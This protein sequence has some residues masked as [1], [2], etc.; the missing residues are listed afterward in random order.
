[1]RTAR[2]VLRRFPGFVLLAINVVMSV[3]L[4][5]GL[6]VGLRSIGPK[7]LGDRMSALRFA[8]RATHEA[9]S[10][11]GWKYETD[12]GRFLRFVPHS[13]FKVDHSEYHNDAWIDE[14]GG[15]AIS[16]PLRD[17]PD[18]VPVFGDSFTFGVGVESEETAVSLLQRTLTQRLLNLGV[19]GSAI[20][21]QRYIL[22][23]RY[24]EL[25]RPK[26]AIFFF[27]L[28]NDFADVLAQKRST[29]RPT[30][31]SRDGGDSRTARPIR[32]LAW[33]VNDFVNSS[34]LRF[35]FALQYARQ[36]ILTVMNRKADAVVANPIFLI[37]SRE[38]SAYRSEVSA[39]VDQ[40]LDKLELFAL[41]VKLR[42]IVVAVPDRN[43]VCSALARSKVTSTGLDYAQLDFS[44]PNALLRELVERHHFPLIDPTSSFEH[45]PDCADLYYT[46]DDHLTAAGQRLLAEAVAP[47]IK[48]ALQGVAWSR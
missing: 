27:F 2:N 32:G 1:M 25:D 28:G 6:E 13:H 40:E 38:Q 7:W 43:Q 47:A 35:S 23:R 44:I 30:G 24:E 10:D 31:V 17:S 34:P 9:G 33:R 36:A 41:G 8:K 39:A 22:E 42:V 12:D 18:I 20:H 16:S 15:R 37:A 29:T 21:A 11:R 5:F 45:R 3:V 26:A 19:P 14:F 48:S 46:Y 4:L